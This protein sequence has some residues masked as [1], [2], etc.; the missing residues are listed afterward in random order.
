MSQ[1]SEENGFWTY[2]NVA[3]ELLKETINI[4]NEYNIDYFLISGTLL[5]QV[6]HN[7]FIPWDDDIDIVVDEKIFEYLNDIVIKYKS[8]LGFIK[9]DDILKL[10]FQDPTKGKVIDIKVLDKYIITEGSKYSFP[11]I[12]IFTY[13]S[14]N[15]RNNKYILFFKK[16]WKY[17]KFFPHKEVLFNNILVRIPNDPHYFLKIN[18]GRDYMTVYKSSNYN[19]KE[20]KCIPNRVTKKIK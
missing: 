15:I 3:I 11:F 13:K 1:F 9:K 7:D 20:E 14:Q 17:D 10:W 4:L 8:K 16:Q 5:G 19:H 2:K 12:D 6:R 18:Y